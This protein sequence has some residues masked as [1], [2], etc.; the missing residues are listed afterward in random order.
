VYLHVWVCSFAV[1]LVLLQNQ[2]WLFCRVGRENP[3]K[4]S[5]DRKVRQ[6]F[7]QN[8]WSEYVILVIRNTRIWENCRHTAGSLLYVFRVDYRF[9]NSITALFGKHNWFQFG[10]FCSENFQFWHIFAKRKMP[11]IVQP[12]SPMNFENFFRRFKCF[13]ILEDDTLT[14]K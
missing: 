8:S 6:L 9:F 10:W 1:V 14:N 5:V 13:K 11:G 3:T 4:F 7:D 2:H 12:F